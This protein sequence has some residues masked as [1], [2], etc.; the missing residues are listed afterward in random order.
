MIVEAEQG[1]R[2][3]TAL[4]PKE[5]QRI[6]YLKWEGQDLVVRKVKAL[7]KIP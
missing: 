6:L 3:L 5:N 2:P 4:P 1:S 7:S